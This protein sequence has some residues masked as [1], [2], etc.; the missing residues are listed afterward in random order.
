MSADSSKE[1]R[2]QQT[3]V[4]N[5]LL[6][7]DTTIRLVRSFSVP[8]EKVDVLIKFCEVAR[9]EAGTRGFSEVLVKAMQ[10]YSKNHEEGNPQLKLTPYVDERAA[11]PVKVLCN[12]LDGAGSNGKIH[13]RRN[14]SWMK[15]I[16]CYPCQ[17][18]RLRKTQ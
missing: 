2:Q 17:Y 18:N 5:K 15:G 10:E 12:Y 4:L 3:S 8:I 7:T 1:T 9:R 14:D 13:C 11:S 16:Q 6:N